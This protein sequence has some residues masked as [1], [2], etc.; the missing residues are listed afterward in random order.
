MDPERYVI[1]GLLLQSAIFRES[2]SCDE[3]YQSHQEHCNRIECEIPIVRGIRYS[4]PFRIT[5][6]MEISSGIQISWLTCL[7]SFIPSIVCRES[8]HLAG[9]YII[10][11]W[12]RSSTGRWFFSYCECCIYITTVI[13]EFCDYIMFTNT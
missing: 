9:D 1:K 10:F 8:S 7:S 4:R 6:R 12:S 11:L 2:L 13:I 3:R 5:V